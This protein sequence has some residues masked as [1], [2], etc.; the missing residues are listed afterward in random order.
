MKLDKE[1]I[2]LIIII[3]LLVIGV[4]LFTSIKT[5]SIIV[6]G[7]FIIALIIYGNKVHNDITPTKTQG[8]MIKR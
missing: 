6:A 4:S 8:A 3:T 2:G 5:S 7:V 1:H